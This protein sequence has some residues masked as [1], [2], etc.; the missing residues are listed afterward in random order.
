MTSGPI[1]EVDCHGLTRDRAVKKIEAVL[2]GA[3]ESAYRIRVI[4][5]YNRGTVIR[6]AVY[7]EFGYGLEPR[8]KRIVPG[9]N[10]GITELILKEY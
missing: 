7:R 8:V 10:M 6:D 3:P 5:G 2:H 9:D 4:H 1:I